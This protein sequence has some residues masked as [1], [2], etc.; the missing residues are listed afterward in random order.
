[1]PVVEKPFKRALFYETGWIVS[2]SFTAQVY[3]SRQK[4]TPTTSLGR[5]PQQTAV[6]SSPYPS[7]KTVFNYLNKEAH[8]GFCLKNSSGALIHERA[9]FPGDGVSSCPGGNRTREPG[10]WI[11]R[12]RTFTTPAQRR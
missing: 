9:A 3:G 8:A 10:G 4:T 5:R 1:M 11:K 12:S 6:R 7:I 2:Y